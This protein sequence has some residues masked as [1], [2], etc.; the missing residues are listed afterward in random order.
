MGKTLFLLFILVL[1]PSSDL[2]FAAETGCIKGDCQNS[3]GI[4]VYHNGSR[5]EGG[6]KDGKYSGRGVFYFA[7]G[8]IYEGEFVDQKLL[9][10]PEGSNPRG[11]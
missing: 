10:M 11:K 1:L 4:M 5:Y 6:F 7:N 2:S 3:S 8:S 9:I